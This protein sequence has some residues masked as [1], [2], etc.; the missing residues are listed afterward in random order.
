MMSNVTSIRH[1][2]P[3]ST[4]I[5]KAVFEFSEALAKAID[6]AKDAGLPQGFLVAPLHAQAMSETQR[7]IG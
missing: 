6:A 2:I 3:V 4:E 5:N 1:A 7:L